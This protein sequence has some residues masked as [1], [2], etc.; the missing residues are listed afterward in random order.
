MG[1]PPDTLPLPPWGCP[2]SVPPHTWR[3]SP[4]HPPPHTRVSQARTSTS[5]GGTPSRR[6]WGR[7]VLPKCRDTLNSLGGQCRHPYGAG[8]TQE[9]GCVASEPI[10]SK[11]DT[12]SP[13]PAH[14][15]LTSALL[16]PPTPPPQ[17]QPPPQRRHRWRLSPGSAPGLRT[18]PDRRRPPDRDSGGA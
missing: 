13:I 3:K 8:A 12:P 10:L 17:G 9:L 11:G 6:E 4:H 16:P 1:A 7:D 5:E 18:W 2:V 15:A 14:V